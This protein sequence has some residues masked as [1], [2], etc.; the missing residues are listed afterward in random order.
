M[1]AFYGAAMARGYL[2]IPGCRAVEIRHL[3]HVTRSMVAL[4]HASCTRRAEAFLA[5]L[6]HRRTRSRTA[7]RFA[8]VQHSEKRV[9]SAAPNLG[10]IRIFGFTAWRA[11]PMDYYLG[12]S[13][14]HA[15]RLPDSP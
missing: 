1:A 12:L 8:D 13:L 4:G 11:A 9:A 6:P 10:R 5:K 15:I 2:V 7:G 3:P 14:P